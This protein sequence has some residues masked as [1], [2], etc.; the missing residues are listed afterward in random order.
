MSV[1]QF[2]SKSGINPEVLLYLASKPS[3]SQNWLF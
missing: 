2:A 3:I 1:K